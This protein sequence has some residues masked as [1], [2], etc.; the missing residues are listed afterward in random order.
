[1]LKWINDNSGLIGILSPI[2]IAAFLFYGQKYFVTN[3]RYEANRKSDVERYEAD[4][5]SIMVYQD[6]ND[7]QHQKMI[8]GQQDILKVVIKQAE[9]TETLKEY[10]TEIRTLRRDV[11]K[12]LFSRSY[13]TNY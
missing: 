1:M 6:K 13:G 12:I 5:K 7:N 11:D 2:L 4:R 10:G 8:D 3:E 9:Q